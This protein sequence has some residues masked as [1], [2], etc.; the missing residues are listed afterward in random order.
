MSI[1]WDGWQRVLLGVGAVA[2]IAAGV[3][4]STYH[5]ASTAGKVPAAVST[6]SA[7]P[8]SAA[9]GPRPAAHPLSS[10]GAVLLHDYTLTI[11]GRSRSFR[12]FVPARTVG[13]A[14]L[15]VALAGLASRTDPDRYMRWRALAQRRHFLVLEPRGYG[16]S[17]NAGRCCGVAA[18]LHVD[19]VDALTAMI[20]SAAHVHAVDRHRVYLVGFSNGGMMAYEYACRRPGAVAA[21]GV[22]AAAYVTPCR[23]SRPVPVMQVHGTVDGVQPYGGGFSPL[24]HMRVPSASQSDAI[25]ARLDSAAGVPAVTVHLR[26][27][28]HAWPRPGWQG[29]YDTTRRLYDFLWRQRS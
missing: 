9:I 15:L 6:P 7:A 17:W 14:P 2:A 5:S 23:P 11:G 16:E 20:A 21:I 24:L 18:R 12:L 28:D 26:G 27:V 8:T 1:A 19:D 3:V 25:F 10:A 22:V 29:G 4:L 13:P